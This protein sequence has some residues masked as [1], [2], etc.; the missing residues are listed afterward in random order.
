MRPWR[1]SPLLGGDSRSVVRLGESDDRHA[2]RMRA[3]RPT[4]HP[5]GGGVGLASTMN[6]LGAAGTCPAPARPGAHAAILEEAPWAPGAV[7]G[8]MVRLEGREFLMGTGDPDGF[9]D[10]GE[11]PVR[12]VRLSTFWIDAVALE[13]AFDGSRTGDLR[14]GKP[15]ASAPEGV[16]GRCALRSTVSGFVRPN[17]GRRSDGHSRLR[18]GVWRNVVGGRVLWRRR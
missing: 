7:P 1:R 10:D 14:L 11:G 16:R 3:Q 18:C 8:T 6:Q 4:L 2:R 15:P 9:P 17:V 12:P 5:G 13:R